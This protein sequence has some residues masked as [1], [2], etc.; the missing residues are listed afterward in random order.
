MKSCSV[1]V[2]F[3]GGCTSGLVVC[4]IGLVLLSV[5]LGDEVDGVAFH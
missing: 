3:V 5:A 4:G 1:K 2:V